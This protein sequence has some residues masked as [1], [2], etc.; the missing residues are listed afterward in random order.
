M[1]H[2]IALLRALN[3]GGHAVVKM[4]DLRAQLAQLQL[5]EL[6][7]VG[8]SG[9]LVIASRHR[10]ASALE[11]D[12][13]AALAEPP[14]SFTGR[15]FVRTPDELARAARGGA[16]RA[17]AK[18]NAAGHDIIYQHLVR[19]EASAESNERAGILRDLA[20]NLDSERGDA[21]RALVVRLAAFTEAPTAADLD[22]L[23][24]L[25]RVTRRWAELPLDTM[26]KLVDSTDDAPPHP[27]AEPPYPWPP[28][29]GPFRP[30]R[31]P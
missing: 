22:P 6:A 23:L 15:V 20:D 31:C 14:A 11:R 29:G 30:P 10:T 5:P 16:K 3:V 2:Y 8:T 13:A 1:P 26:A 17:N 7:T 12:L 9:N 18:L 19:V 25:A 4:A 24:R 27:L 21:D 28:H